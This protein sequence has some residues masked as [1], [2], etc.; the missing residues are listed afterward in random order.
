MRGK[1][2]KEKYDQRDAEPPAPTASLLPALQRSFTSLSSQVQQVL[3]KS[4]TKTPV[5]QTRVNSTERDDPHS[6]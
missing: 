3:P 5:K 6:A 4:P 2:I 1:A